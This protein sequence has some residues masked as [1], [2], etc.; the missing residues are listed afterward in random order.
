[1]FAPILPVDFERR[2]EGRHT[3]ELADRD[4]SALA[5]ASRATKLQPSLVDQPDLRWRVAFLDTRGDVLHLL[6]LDKTMWLRA[7]RREGYIDGNKCRFSS[8]LGDWLQ[9]RFPD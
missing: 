5:T 1:M 2:S 9:A 6:F 8:E 4:V 3:L 7:G